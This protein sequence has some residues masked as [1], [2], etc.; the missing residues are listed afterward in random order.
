MVNPLLPEARV[1]WEA[2]SD[3]CSGTASLK[4]HK[5]EVEWGS[6]Q[7]GGGYQ[8]WFNCVQEGVVI[9]KLDAWAASKK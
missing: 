4:S 9:K 6:A 8:V 1:G 7:W 3:Q 5:E 2:L